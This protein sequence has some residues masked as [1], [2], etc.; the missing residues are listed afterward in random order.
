M[1]VVTPVQIESI[2]TEL[3]AARDAGIKVVVSGA[4]KEGYDQYYDA[5][6]ISDEFLLGSNIALLA[7]HWAEKALAGQDYDVVVCYNED[8]DDGRKRSSGMK[9]IQEP[10]LKNYDGDYINEAGAVVDDSHKITNPCYLPQ[11]SLEGHFHYHTQSVNISSG[12]DYMA[13]ITNNFPKAKVILCYMSGFSAQMST[14]LKNTYPSN[15][16]DYGIFAGGVQGTEPN[17]ILGSLESGVG[18]SFQYMGETKTGAESVFRGAVS[19][20]GSDAAKSL[21]SL[22]KKVYEGKEGTDY[23]KVNAEALGVW[24]TS[25]AQDD[26]PDTLAVKQLDVP[27]NSPVTDFDPLTCVKNPSENDTTILWQNK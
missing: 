21:A 1:I 4:N 13:E 23:Q 17:Y 18:K 7:K 8:N 26:I 25:K 3:K 6:T 20:G 19:F 12:L 5:V 16:K 2:T 24:F 10:Y 27:F 14:Y 15:Y 22:S 11:A 9:M